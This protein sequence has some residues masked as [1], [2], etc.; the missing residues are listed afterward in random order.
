[1]RISGGKLEESREDQVLYQAPDISA[2]R[3]CL[4]HCC[5]PSLNRGTLHYDRI[6]HICNALWP[7]FLLLCGSLAVRGLQ[8]SAADVN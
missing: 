1:M 8:R 2:R 6:D 4:Q 7:A 3:K 5:Q